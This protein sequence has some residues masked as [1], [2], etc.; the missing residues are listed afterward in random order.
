MNGQVQSQC[1]A[2]QMQRESNF[3]VSSG[4]PLSS[5]SGDHSGTE[6]SNLI[7]PTSAWLGIGVDN[8]IGI[9]IR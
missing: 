2:M 9:G 1:N 8:S 5:D 7:H 3:L 6:F 4:L